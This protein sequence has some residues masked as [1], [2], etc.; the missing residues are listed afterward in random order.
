MLLVKQSFQQLQSKHQL[1]FLVSEHLI[2]CNDLTNI[3][4]PE[5]S[6]LKKIGSSAFG[7]YAVRSIFIPSSV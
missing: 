4:I 2:I 1:K 6:R 3:N 7:E 5:D